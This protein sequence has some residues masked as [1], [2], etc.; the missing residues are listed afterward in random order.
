MR[1]FVWGMVYESEKRYPLAVAELARRSGLSP[2]SPPRITTWLRFIARWGARRI[3][4]EF[5]KVRR[6]EAASD[7]G[8]D[9]TKEKEE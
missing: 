6:I 1:I 2:T 5:A 4:A 8:V 3:P 7:N 9:V